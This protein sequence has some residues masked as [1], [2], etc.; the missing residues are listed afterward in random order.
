M[1][2]IHRP[3]MYQ[4]QKKADQLLREAAEAIRMAVDNALA[5]DP[6]VW[7]RI[8]DVAERIEKLLEG[9]EG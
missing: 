9:G 8:I 7:N 4:K 2:K 6:D 1:P 5:D 3:E